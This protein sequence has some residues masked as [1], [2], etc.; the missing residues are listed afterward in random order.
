[1]LMHVECNMRYAKPVDGL[2]APGH[3][4]LVFRLVSSKATLTTNLLQPRIKLGM[5]T[6]Q[7]GCGEPASFLR[8][9]TLP[10]HQDHREIVQVVTQ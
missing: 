10:E 7:Q 8:F 2:N 1:M 3:A 5:G 4:R 9:K 6:L